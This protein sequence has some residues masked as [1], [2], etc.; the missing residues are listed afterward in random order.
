MIQKIE[1]QRRHLADHGWLQTFHLFSFADYHDPENIHWGNLRVFNDDTI[2]GEQGFDAHDHDNMEIVTLVFDGALTHRD[3][4]GN[5]G[6]IKAGEVQYMSAGTGVTHA[7]MNEGKEPVHLY[8]IWI[9]PRKQGLPPQYQQRD[10]TSL[11]RP[12]VLVPVASGQKRE[13]TLTLETD[14]T[15]YKCTLQKGKTIDHKSHAHQGAFVYVHSGSIMINETLFKK[16]DQARIQN[17]DHLTITAKSDSQFVL[18]DTDMT[19]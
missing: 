7:E 10:F 18:I 14:A 16:H 9:F 8:Q 5:K 1:A 3:S 2:A 13:K 15:I 4:M 6:I 11:L 19:V 12:N 17:E